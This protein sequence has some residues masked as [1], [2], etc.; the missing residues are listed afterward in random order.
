MYTCME[1]GIPSGHAGN[2]WVMA[3]GVFGAPCPPEPWLVAGEGAGT[4][5]VGAVGFGAKNLLTVKRDF[6][7]WCN[8][9]WQVR[10]DLHQDP[11]DEHLL[12]EGAY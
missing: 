1:S 8:C 7:K 9:R 10:T 4:G 2:A 3:A 6:K 12:C 5:G 11:S